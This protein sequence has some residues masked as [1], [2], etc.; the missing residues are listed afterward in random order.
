MNNTCCLRI[1]IHIFV[2]CGVLVFHN[3]QAITSARTAEIKKFTQD[4]TTE[5]ITSPTV[6]EATMRYFKKGLSKVELKSG[7]IVAMDKAV[8]KALGEKM[9]QATFMRDLKNVSHFFNQAVILSKIDQDVL[10]KNID[11]FASLL[12]YYVKHSKHFGRKTEVL[13][14]RTTRWMIYVMFR[15]DMLK[16]HKV[17]V[18][19]S[20]TTLDGID[21]SNLFD[22]L[23]KR[24]IS[25]Q[26][27]MK[28]GM[29][30]V[31]LKIAAVKPRIEFCEGFNAN[32]FFESLGDYILSEDRKNVEIIKAFCE[33]NYEK[34]EQHQ[35]GGRKVWEQEFGQEKD[36]E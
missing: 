6:V 32:T 3:Q 10:V 1:V 18:A 27:Y 26:E 7:V 11:T 29:T 34:L 20:R 14:M 21:L 31:I 19:F 15:Q 12:N 22:A 30:R 9:S 4:V 8:D 5:K 16:R 23:K 35:D 25:P 36:M 17:E 24:T 2:F 13:F 33:K 28:G